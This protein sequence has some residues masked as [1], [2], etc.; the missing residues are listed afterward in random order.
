MDYKQMNRVYKGQKVICI[1]DHCE[2]KQGDIGTI[3]FDY[4]GEGFYYKRIQLDDGRYENLDTWYKY[5][6]EV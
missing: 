1:K 4:Y 5:W 6:D 2:F 3:H